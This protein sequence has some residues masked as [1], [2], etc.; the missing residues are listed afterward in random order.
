MIER[1]PWIGRVAISVLVS[2]ATLA[3]W[4]SAIGGPSNDVP[5]AALLTSILQQPE[6]KL[7]FATV[8]LTVDKII[9][10]RIDVDANLRR[11]EAIITTINA[12]AGVNASSDKKIAALRRYLYEPGPWNNYAAY[13]YDFDDPEG[14]K[15]SN[16]L[17]PNYLATKKG[18]CISM[19][20]L[21]IVLGQRLGLDVAAATAPEH[22]LVKYTDDA[23]TTHNLEATSGGKPQREVWIRQQIPMTDDAVANGVYLRKLSKRETAAVMA[24]VLAE[25]FAERK[26][27]EKQIAIADVLLSVR[28]RSVEP[29]L[30]KGSAYSHL[31]RERYQSRYPSPRDIPMAE[32]ADFRFLSQQTEFWYAKAESLGWR[33]PDQRQEDRY[34]QTVNRAKA[35]R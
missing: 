32:V 13:R 17:L 21:F 25:H 20:V 15:I 27:Y 4:K 3:S 28:P 1:K 24:E 22:V 26:D 34:K 2:A 8:K 10:P 33:P 5:E 6:D 23:G 31:I 11:I 18:Q 9:D 16:K 19:P 30:H 7:D 12:M 14:R 29:M 35:A